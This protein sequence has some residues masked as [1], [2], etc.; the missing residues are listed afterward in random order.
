LLLCQGRAW[1]QAFFADLAVYFVACSAIGLVILGANGQ[2][3]GSALRGFL[4]WLPA[5][6]AANAAGMFVGFRLPENTF[7]RTTLAL[8]FAAGIATT[9]TA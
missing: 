8:A 7:R 5:V 1:Q 4:W 2:F 6:L 3:S 9:A